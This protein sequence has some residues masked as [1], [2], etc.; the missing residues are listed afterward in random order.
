MTRREAASLDTSIRGLGAE[1]DPVRIA[2]VAAAGLALDRVAECREPLRRVVDALRSGPVVAD[3]LVSFPVLCA[4]DIATGR[5]DEAVEIAEEGIVMCERHGRPL[6]AA[7][8]HLALALLAAARGDDAR[9][10]ALV[11]R[12]LERRGQRG[13]RVLVDEGRRVLALSALAR[14]DAEEAHRQVVA[15]TTPGLLAGAGPTA[16]RV[17]MDLVQSAA[18]LG[19][20]DE[21]R[22]HARAMQES[23]AGA[24]STRFA[25]VTVAAAALV[26]APDAA[27]GLFEAALA[28]PDADRW[29]FDQARIQ[30]AHGEHLRRTRRTGDSRVP[31]AAA[32]DTFLRLRADPWAARAQGELRATGMTVRQPVGAAPPAL[33]PEER[34]VA[35]LAAA[36][37]TNKQIARRLTVSHH[38]VAARLYQVFPKLGVGSRTALRGAMLALDGGSGPAALG[39]TT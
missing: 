22:R 5:W 18:Q 17:S 3:A 21:A 28:S 13:V 4:G 10:R 7:S 12:A 16:L 35:A 32:L 20:W 25:M 11:D 19:R 27:D 26:A 36:G 37:L 9:T 14:G 34:A 38:T 31:L 1:C 23:P 6:Q 15:I 29:P 39:G 2:R 30:L 33:T 8:L 24:S